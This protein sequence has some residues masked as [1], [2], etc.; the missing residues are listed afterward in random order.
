MIIWDDDTA[1]AVRGATR[2]EDDGPLVAEYGLIAVLGATIAGLAIRWASGGAI[3]ELLGSILDR[4]KGLV[5][6]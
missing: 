3:F 5:G 6:V 4:V 1:R 2:N